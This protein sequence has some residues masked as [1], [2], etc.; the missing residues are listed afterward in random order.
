MLYSV[1]VPIYSALYF[2]LFL[3]PF[4]MIASFILFAPLYLYLSMLVAALYGRTYWES[5]ALAEGQA[6]EA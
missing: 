5:V 4:L 3:M 1:L 2:T 6:G